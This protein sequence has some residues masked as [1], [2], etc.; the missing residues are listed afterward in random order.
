M[1]SVEHLKNFLMGLANYSFILTNLAAPN[2]TTQEEWAVKSSSLLAGLVSANVITSQQSS[3][4]IALGSG[5]RYGVVTGADV[6][7][8]RTDYNDMLAQEEAKGKQKK[9][10]SL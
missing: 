6:A 5:L 1:L 8:S 3:G 9:R 10:N 4:F 2:A 7:Q